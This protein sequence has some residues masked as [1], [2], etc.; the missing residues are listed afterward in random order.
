MYIY[1]IHAYIN[2]NIYNHICIYIVKIYLYNYMRLYI[3]IYYE[4]KL[5]FK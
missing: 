1:I 2:I 4:Q 5:H 3:Q